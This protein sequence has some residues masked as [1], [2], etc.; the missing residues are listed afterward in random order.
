MELKVI[1]IGTHVHIGTKDDPIIATVS[2]VCVRGEAHGI[3]YECVWWDGKSRT[4]A[5]CDES[6]VTPTD[7]KPSKTTIGFAG[8]GE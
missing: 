8:G 1:Q 5:W 7:K 2:A 3:Q 6:E 4:T